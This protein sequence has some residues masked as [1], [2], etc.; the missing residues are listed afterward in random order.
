MGHAGAEGLVLVT[1][2]FPDI[3]TV[4]GWFRPFPWLRVLGTAWA[5]IVLAWPVSSQDGTRAPA[6]ASAAESLYRATASSTA[7][8]G[9]KGVRLYQSNEGKPRWKM[10]AEGAEIFRAENYCLFQRIDAEF[11]STSGN[12]VRSSSD[13]GSSKLNPQS[14]F[15]EIELQGNVVVVSSQGYRMRVDTLVYDGPKHQLRSGDPVELTGPDPAKPAVVLKGKGLIG[16]VEVERFRLLKDVTVDRQLSGSERRLK[17]SARTGEFFTAEHRAVFSKNAK[18][19]LPE[20][21]VQADRI[22]LAFGGALESMQAQGGVRLKSRDR[23]GRA[24]AA[25]FDLSTGAVVLKGTAEVS[26]PEG[27]VKGNRISF[28]MDGDRFEVDSA[29]GR[30]RG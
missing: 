28:D 11:F 4:K 24:D 21:E 5:A 25:T 12:V 2:R 30:Q 29:E 8:L 20:L 26:S 6:A 1:R 17:V 7:M 10:V 16:D 14:D 18:A 3:A 27:E 23:Q 22:E 13:Y 9:L 15:E 19:R